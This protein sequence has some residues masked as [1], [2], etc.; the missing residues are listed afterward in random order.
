[1]WLQA[2]ALTFADGLEAFLVIAATVAFLRRT[3]QPALISAVT[4]GIAVS[5]VTSGIGAWLFSRAD[6]QPLWEG[7]FAL[8]AAFAIAGLTVYMW[9]TRSRL[10][11]TAT[12]ERG[13]T[14]SRAAALVFFLATALV[15][16][17]EGM[18]TVLLI[19]TFVV[20]IR[21]PALTAGVIAGLVLAALIAW[22]WA[23]HA[24]RLR[25]SLFVPVTA[26]VLAVV[27]SQLISD[28]LQNLANASAPSPVMPF[29]SAP[30]R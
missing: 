10:T 7:R 6:N 9:R 2:F 11:D 3:R 28:A 29:D 25:L 13:A 22:W 21:V 5:I 14:T 23:R 1:L 27:L 4:W 30:E 16:S 19:G 24:H 12:L 20:Q 17:R 15:V 8:A 18:H 26:L